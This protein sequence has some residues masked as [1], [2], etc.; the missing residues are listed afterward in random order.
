LIEKLDL[1]ERGWVISVI[2]F[3]R[4]IPVGCHKIKK[5]VGMRILCLK[6]GEVGFPHVEGIQ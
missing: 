2:F 6:I 3:G 1:W 5:I 4:S